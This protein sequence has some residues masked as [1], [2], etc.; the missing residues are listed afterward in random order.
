MRKRNKSIIIRNCVCLILIIFFVFDIQNLISMD[1]N[2]KLAKEVIKLN[3]VKKRYDSI[4]KEQLTGD[5]N[6]LNKIE[7]FKRVYLIDEQIGIYEKSNFYTSN[8][9]FKIYYGTDIGNSIE[10]SYLIA[11]SKN[12]K[13]Y[14]LFGFDNQDF[15]IFLQDNL[16]PVNK[17]NIIYLIKLYL[18][19]VKYDYFGSRIFIDD[20][21]KMISIKADN[22]ITLPEVNDESDGLYAKI[23]T[24][25][26]YTNIL[27]KYHFRFFENKL[28]LQNEEIIDNNRNLQ[29]R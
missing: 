20:K 5:I 19:T 15:D 22:D 8:S 2:Q 21:E 3:I 24:Y 23:F 13:Y 29:N 4:Y 1:F 6:F 26:T 27:V 16:L 9:K 18:L 11:I 12:G 25:D 17:E 14:H 28:Y 7:N 10:F